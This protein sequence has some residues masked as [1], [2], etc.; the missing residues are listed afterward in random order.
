MNK[1][2]RIQ[3]A[4][5][6][7]PPQN[8]P[9]KFGGDLN[10][11][12]KNENRIPIY[13][14]D[15]SEEDNEVFFINNSKKAL[16]CVISSYSG[17]WTENKDDQKFFYEN[18]LPGEAVKIDDFDPIYDY[19][20]MIQQDVFIE[21]LEGNRTR[22]FCVSYGSIIPETILLYNDNS[23]DK[24]VNIQELSKCGPK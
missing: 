8:R 22:F 2:K 19:K 11:Y 6:W 16:K 5:E 13:V 17:E 18:V 12:P 9:S 3:D 7:I 4:W 10:V 24:G 21:D 14:I 1:E 20:E 15:S 23:R